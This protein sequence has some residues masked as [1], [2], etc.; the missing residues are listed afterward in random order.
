MI[1]TMAIPAIPEIVPVPEHVAGC[2]SPVLCLDGSWEYCSLPD[3]AGLEA[4]RKNFTDAGKKPADLSGYAWREIPVPSSMD[5]EHIPGF[6]GYWL[7]RKTVQ[8]P[9]CAPGSRMVL[10]FEGTNAHVWLYVNGTP[11]AAHENGMITWNADITAA[12]GSARTAEILL[13]GDDRSERVSTFNHGGILHDVYLLMLPTYYLASFHADA[14][15]VWLSDRTDGSLTVTVSV[16]SGH[17]TGLFPMEEEA[18]NES[19]PSKISD[20]ALRFRLLGPDG[21]EIPMHPDQVDEIS[22]TVATAVTVGSENFLET[23]VPD[24][25]GELVCRFAVPAPKLWDAEHPNLYRL[26]ICLTRGGKIT[27]TVC[28]KVGFRQIERRGNRVFINRQE[29]KLHGTCRHEVTPLNGR[30]VPAETIAKDVALFKEANINYVRTSHYPPSEHFLDL[31][32]EKGIYVEDEL[33]LA[34]I[35]RSLDYTEQNPREAGRYLSHFAETYARDGSHPCVIIWSLCNESFC[36]TN[37]DLL[38]RFAKRTDPTRLTKFSY[39]MTMREDYRP[40]DIWS[41]HYANEEDDPSV[42]RDNVGVG[43]A[44]GKTMPVLHDEYVHVPCYNRSEQRRDPG[45]REFWGKSIARFW[46][47]IWNTEGAL[48]G[49]IWAG[50]DETDLYVGGN[51][52]HLEW[53]IIDLWR[54]RKPEHTMVRRAYSPVVLRGV[55]RLTEEIRAE[56]GETNP[57]AI[58]ILPAAGSA[59][60]GDVLRIPVENRFCHTNLAE[61]TFAGWYLTAQEAGDLSRDACERAAQ[62]GKA[63]WSF[64]LPGPDIPPRG[65]G[66]VNVPF[67]PDAAYLYLTFTDGCGNQVSEDLI[68]LESF[69]GEIPAAQNSFEVSVK[70]DSPAISRN[71]MEYHISTRTGRFTEI[72]RNG[73]VQI[74]DGPFLRAAYLQLPEWQA[75]EIT[76]DGQTVDS[77]AAPELCLTGDFDHTVMVRGSFG[78][79]MGLTWTYRIG[80]D[81]S[82]GIRFHVDSLRIAMPRRIKLR[83]GV[84]CGGL[85]ELGIT[86]ISAQGTDRIS[87]E[88]TGDY[89]V[90]PEDFIGRNRGTACKGSP[91]RTE[92]FGTRPDHP[93]KEDT[94]FDIKNGRWDPGLR[95]SNDFCSAK[96]N[97]ANARIFSGTEDG[98]SWKVLPVPQK[99]DGW[100]QENPE[101]GW[102]SEAAGM[103]PGSGL[104][105]RAE[106]LLRRDRE[107]FC[108]DPRLQYSG[109][110]YRMETPDRYGA[111]TEMCAEE[112]GASVTIRFRGTGIVWYGSADVNYGLADLSLDGK[113][114]GRISQKVDGVDFPGSAEGFDRRDHIAVWSV[115]GLDDAEHTLTV[116]AAGACA[117]DA[118]GNLIALECFYILRKG[119][120]QETAVHLLHARNFPQISWGNWK[121]P[122]ILLRKGDAEEFLLQF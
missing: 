56:R 113:P 32:D 99:A 18:T 66:Q 67:C 29:V 104:T 54:R 58:G 62:S 95:G 52:T 15:P 76:A 74:T 112:K 14:V 48:G 120:L 36:G 82:L 89:S 28:R 91:E 49:A 64:R 114:A 41:I 105:L 59:G 93:W 30:S 78:G 5:R 121:R 69:R 4:C 109:K 27:E 88:R 33:A 37:F 10:R 83:V 23:N 8:L 42:R 72:L 116:T 40:V 122:P 90:Y 106:G 43:G 3:A 119:D 70:P 94:H 75:E 60:A 101:N 110:W 9:S 79:A 35:A 71:A 38:N 2:S 21:K 73:T 20:R 16:K 45:V 55:N 26:E 17:L 57:P 111:R 115:S 7:C 46:D 96:E 103:F 44:F 53:G 47:R 63:V 25:G 85:D 12:V 97:L 117:P 87:W 39:P 24:G 102:M 50:I 6:T 51:D 98:L 77:A 11:V 61:G 1:R 22:G 81:G 92:P 34:F 80:R 84:D 31:C 19:E 100:D 86:M 107:I 68:D 13:A 65:T 108:G 118:K